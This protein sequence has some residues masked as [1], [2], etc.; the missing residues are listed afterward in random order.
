MTSNQALNTYSYDSEIPGYNGFQGNACL[1]LTL[2]S[3]GDEL[4]DERERESMRISFLRAFIDS[5]QLNPYF[6]DR[7]KAKI[8]IPGASVHE[9]GTLLYPELESGHAVIERM[10][11]RAA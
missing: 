5:L 2:S 6:T 11:G 10:K 3:Q 1:N 9:D 8:I 4:L 7:D